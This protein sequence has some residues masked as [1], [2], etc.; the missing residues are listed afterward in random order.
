MSSATNDSSKLLVGRLNSVYGIKGWLKVTSYTEPKDNL[1]AYQPCY[2]YRN[3]QW[4]E[5]EIAQWR[6]HN[7]GLVA[8]LKG[9][10]DRESA[11]ALTGTDIFTE[12][13][14][15]PE[16]TDGEYYWKDLIGLQVVNSL[17]EVFGTVDHLL[18][19]GAND[20]LVVKPSPHSID[21]RERLIPYLLDQTVLEIDV[22]AKTIRV[23][24]DADF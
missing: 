11:R 24:W 22:K 12:S 20:V 14:V 16:L 6:R 23:E 21:D 7:Q 1:F 10:E 5:I 19:T 8:Q 13:D 2:I 4:Q 18:E 3:Q 15:L 17:G 9:I